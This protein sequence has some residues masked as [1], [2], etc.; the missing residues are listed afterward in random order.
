M[1][2]IADILEPVEARVTALYNTRDIAT[3][4]YTIDTMIEELNGGGDISKPFD[5]YT[6]QELSIISGKLSIL[7]A[8]I[9]KPKD[10]A[11]RNMKRLIASRDL[12]LP[13][14]RGS[15]I[16]YLTDQANLAGTKAP[17]Q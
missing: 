17:T 7:R 8:S 10:E 2:S 5:T 1:S 15:V 9:L 14:Q 13:G 12:I 16:K 4:L 11:F 6:T 3:L